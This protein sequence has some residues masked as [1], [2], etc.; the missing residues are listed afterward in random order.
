M[1]VQVVLVE[2]KIDCLDAGRVEFAEAQR[3]AA[4]LE[5]P[6][7]RISVI[8]NLN[9]KNLFVYLA[10]TLQGKFLSSLSS[11][12]VGS[13]AFFVTNVDDRFQPE[14]EVVLPPPAQGDAAACIVI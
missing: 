13:D 4:Q 11:L 5:A 14:T 6:L 10:T 7:F 1:G 3:M 9:L 12:P 8:E 2:N